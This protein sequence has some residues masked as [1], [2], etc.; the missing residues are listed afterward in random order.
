VGNISSLVES[1]DWLG[2]NLPSVLPLKPSLTFPTFPVL[3]K[4]L[5]LKVY[6]KLSCNITCLKDLYQLHCDL[7]MNISSFADKVKALDLPTNWPDFSTKLLTDTDEQVKYRLPS[8]FSKSSPDGL[9]HKIQNVIRILSLKDPTELF[10]YTHQNTKQKQTFEEITA[11]IDSYVINVCEDGVCSLDLMMQTN[12]L[13]RSILHFPL[14]HIW[15]KLIHI[16]QI[17][18]IKCLENISSLV[19]EQIGIAT[20]DLINIEFRTSLTTPCHTCLDSEFNILSRK[21]SLAAAEIES[22]NHTTIKNSKQRSAS[23]LAEINGFIEELRME[24][25]SYLL[26]EISDVQ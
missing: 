6:P 8:T 17:Y 23:L 18:R 9:G 21:R 15:R 26:H 20:M 4:F 11:Q 10:N 16:C 1:L 3:A 22:T 2:Q 5:I 24:K 12:E 14:C 13:K 25:E 7:I 19:T